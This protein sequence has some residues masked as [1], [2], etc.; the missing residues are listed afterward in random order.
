MFINVFLI[1]IGYKYLLNQSLGKMELD[2]LE[3]LW[4]ENNQEEDEIMLCNNEDVV[5]RSGCVM[6]PQ[7]VNMQLFY[8][9]TF[10]NDK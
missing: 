7:P 4:E 3:S 2:E 1:M 9:N 8:G 5:E 6:T 10:H